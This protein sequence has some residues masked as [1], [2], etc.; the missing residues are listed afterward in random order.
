MLVLIVRQLEK[1]KD[2]VINMRLGIDNLS[3]VLMQ[4]GKL[5]DDQFKT[6]GSELG[7]YINYRF[8]AFDKLPLLQKY[9]VTSQIRKKSFDS[10]KADKLKAICFR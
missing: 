4:G 1:L 5:T 6:F 3:G 8:K 10:L 9:K 2:S 7:G